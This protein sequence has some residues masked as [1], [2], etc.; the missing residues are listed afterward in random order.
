M[1]APMKRIGVIA[2]KTN[3]NQTTVEVGMLSAS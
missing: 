1:I 3:W 2:A